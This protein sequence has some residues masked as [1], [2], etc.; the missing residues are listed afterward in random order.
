MK[1]KNSFAIYLIIFSAAIFL[2]SGCGDDTVTNN[3]VTDNGCGSNHALHYGT[4]TAN[5]YTN[6][7]LES[8][9]TRVF[10]FSAIP[11]T[12]ISNICTKNE[13]P[14]SGNFAW[15]ASDTS[16]PFT[17]ELVV[18]V[19]PVFSPY[20]TLGT[21]THSGNA[22]TWSGNINAGLVQAYGD[23]PGEIIDLRI[24][25]SFRSLGSL[26]ADSL[27][28]SNRSA[29]CSMDLHYDEYRAP[30]NRI[31]GTVNL[32]DANFIF[33]NNKNDKNLIYPML[34]FNKDL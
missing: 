1:K 25:V 8:G 19:S 23:G 2:S 6:T 20:I 14:A 18:N 31:M 15:F 10:Q 22:Y 28:L 24:D 26:F 32:Q 9:N 27:L 21:I 16:H 11:F 30:T 34:R 29:A 12:T 7:L 17:V 4:F 5:Q 13:P 33:K 3:T